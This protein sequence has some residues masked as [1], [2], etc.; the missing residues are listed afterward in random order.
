VAYNNDNQPGVIVSNLPHVFTILIPLTIVIY[1][2]YKIFK[3]I[4]QHK[5]NV[6]PS[7]NPSGLGTSVQEIKVTWVL[8]A[9]L[10]GYC[11][12]WI[13][14][15]GNLVAS[16]I[17]S[18]YNYDLPRQVHILVTYA[19]ASSSIINPIIY[20]VSSMAFRREYKK[21]LGLK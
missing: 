20:G 7:S 9:V 10:L 17:C 12:T 11:L 4:R 5:R 13:P 19:M 2:Y 14:V 3:K 15:L 18:R 16:N 1:C 8:F 21:I 6:A